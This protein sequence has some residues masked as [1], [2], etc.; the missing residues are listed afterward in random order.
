MIDRKKDRETGR[1]ATILGWKGHRKRL[2]ER[3]RLH[4]LSS[5]HDYEALELLLFYAVPR[6]D[7]K[8]LAKGLILAFGGLRGVFDASFEDLKKI[9]GMGENASLLLPLVKALGSAYLKERALEG[10]QLSCTEDL[11][12]YCMA[13]MGGL[14]D[15]RFTVIFLNTRNRIIEVEDIQ[16]G[17]VN[18]AVVYPRKIL[19]K[20]LQH[21]ASA[22]ILVHN[23]PSGNTAPSEADVRLTRAVQETAKILDIRIHDHLIIGGNRYFSFRG[24]G[25]LS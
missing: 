6:K 25:L 11:V 23:H 10:E 17:T 24:E 21:K 22:M 13:S 20:A 9:P 15:E 16:D 7:V 14:K 18:Q 3:F 2:K 8:P 4:G 1:T 5:L 12:R 19:E